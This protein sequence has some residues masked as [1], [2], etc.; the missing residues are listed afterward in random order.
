MAASP[1]FYWIWSKSWR[2]IYKVVLK[3]KIFFQHT[4]KWYRSYLYLCL[5]SIFVQID[6]LSVATIF[7]NWQGDR[8]QQ[9]FQKELPPKGKLPLPLLW[10]LTLLPP[11]SYWHNCVW[12]QQIQSV[13]CQLKNRVPG[14]KLM[15]IIKK[16]DKKIRTYTG[17]VGHLRMDQIE[18]IS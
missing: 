3:T 12:S 9:N 17:T 18:D 4:V 14:I 13:S 2:Q 15:S 11:L 10:S 1:K 7:L 8:L 5:V 6:L 16:T